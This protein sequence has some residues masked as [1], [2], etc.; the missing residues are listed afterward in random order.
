MNIDAIENFNLA[1]KFNDTNPEMYV[2]KGCALIN[3]VKI[4]KKSIYPSSIKLKTQLYIYIFYIEKLQRRFE[5][6]KKSTEN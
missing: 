1:L 2:A 5:R 3:T 6:I 4:N